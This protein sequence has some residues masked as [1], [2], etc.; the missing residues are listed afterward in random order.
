MIIT[1]LSTDEAVESVY[2]EL[3]AGQEASLVQDTTD[4]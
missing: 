4:T 2:A 1:S 3:L